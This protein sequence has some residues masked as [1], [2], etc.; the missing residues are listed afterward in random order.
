MSLPGPDGGGDD[1]LF[2]ASQG[3][4]HTTGYTLSGDASNL[5][6][7]M[8][9]FW[10]QFDTALSGLPACLAQTLKEYEHTHQKLYQQCVQHRQDLA[11]ALEN[12][13]DLISAVD[14]VCAAAFTDPAL[15]NVSL[16][17][18]LAGQ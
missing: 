7:D 8:G 13:T 5:Q 15:A 16:S 9:V 1:G 10:S 14:K 12:S 2:V 4:M 18:L 3:T 6:S 17:N 11:T